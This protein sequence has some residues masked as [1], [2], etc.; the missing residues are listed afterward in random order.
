MTV[1]VHPVFFLFFFFSLS[2]LSAHDTL[3][4]QSIILVQA[5]AVKPMYR[6]NNNLNLMMA[7]V[8]DLGDCQSD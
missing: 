7:P 5:E 6:G 8:K 3:G 4:G 1:H 2:S